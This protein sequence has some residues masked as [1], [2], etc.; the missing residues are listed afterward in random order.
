[1]LLLIIRII[2]PQVCQRNKVEYPSCQG[3]LAI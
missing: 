2:R 1:M 3:G